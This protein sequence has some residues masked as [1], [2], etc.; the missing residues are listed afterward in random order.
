MSGELGMFPFLLH[1][2]TSPAPP[3]LTNITRPNPLP[4]QTRVLGQPRRM[5]TQS[6]IQQ[7]RRNVQREAIRFYGGQRGGHGVGGVRGKRCGERGWQ[8]VDD[9][10]ESRGFGIKNWET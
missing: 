5:L 3:P 9:G 4:P 8:D 10:R 1:L 6:L 2:P 7:G